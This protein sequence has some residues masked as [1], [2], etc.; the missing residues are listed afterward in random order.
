MI[1]LD[2]IE[3]CPATDCQDGK[4]LC[5]DGSSAVENCTICNGKGFKIKDDRLNR[6]DPS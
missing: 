5:K 1:E 6:S 3:L 4:A 2:D